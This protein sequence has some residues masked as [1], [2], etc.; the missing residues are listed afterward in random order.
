MET[1][2]LSAGVPQSLSK[3]NKPGNLTILDF[4]ATKYNFMAS[5]LCNHDS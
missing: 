2:W 5:Q 1:S 4:I 3:A